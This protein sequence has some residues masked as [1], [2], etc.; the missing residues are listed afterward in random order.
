MRL[1]RIDL[2]RLDLPLTVPYALA[3]GEIRA[4]DT[5]V[6]RVR[7]SEG[8]SGLGEATI[9]TGYT[10]ETID[11]CWRLARGLARRMAG[12]APADARAA[13]S[14]HFGAAPFTV[15]ALVSAVEMLEDHPLLRIEALA[16]V[17][18][19]GLL[20]ASEPPALEAELDELMAAGY[21]TLKVKVGFDVDDDLARLARIQRAVAGRLPIRID[22]NQGYTRD[23]ALRFA[24][25]LDP[26]GLE[27][28]EQPC[29]AHDWEAAAAVARV[30][31]VPLMLDESIYGLADVD[32]AAELG[33]GYVKFKLM[34]AGGLTSLAEAL[35]HI[36][37]LGMEPVLGN[38][39]AHEV[40]CWMEACVARTTIRNAGEMNGFLNPRDR[41]LAQPL[42][43]AGGAL[44]LEPGF[45]PALDEAAVARL[46]VATETVG[47]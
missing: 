24:G 35:A 37:A 40:G 44:T 33:A 11:E 13:A 8:R 46:A 41:V 2:F 29:G 3:L 4:F 7:D 28:F 15:T 30:S 32:R 16:T 34:K 9:L 42:A 14:A 22:A 23:E 36:R 31:P 5:V 12:L 1:D 19:L 43:F 38:G 26:A 39:V 20:H 25:A 47:G 27:L 17:P 18:L 6:V 21:T 45:R 10:E